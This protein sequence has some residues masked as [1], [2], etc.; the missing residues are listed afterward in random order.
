MEQ[1]LLTRADA[2]GL[3]MELIEDEVSRDDFDKGFEQIQAFLRTLS[4]EGEDAELD[5]LLIDLLDSLEDKRSEL[6]FAE[7]EKVWQASL[8]EKEAVIEELRSLIQEE[9]NIGK[10]FQSF[11]ELRDKWEAIGEVS[12]EQYSRVHTEYSRLRE[13]FFYNISIYKEL[14]DHDKKVNL[15]LKKEL[16]EKAKELANEKNIQAADSGIKEVIKKWDDIGGTFQ[17]EWELV[18]EEF[19]AASRT[20]LDRVNAYYSDQRERMAENLQKKNQLITQ[21]TDIADKDRS[22]TKEWNNATE[23]VLKIQEEWKRIGFSAENEKVWRSFREACD[24]FFKAKQGFYDQIKEVFEERKKRKLILIQK[25]A[26]MKD[27]SDWRDASAEIIAI[28]NEW[29]EVGS[30]S[31]KDENKLWNTFRG[32]CDAFFNNRN[33]HF[34][35]RDSEEK[36]NLKL[37]EEVIVELKTFKPTGNRNKDIESVRALSDRWNAVGHVPFKVK[38]KVYKEYQ[39][40]L[41][42]FYGSVKMDAQEKSKMQ[43]LSRVETLKGNPKA[44]NR[45]KD[46]LRNEIK[47]L[48]DDIRQYENNL[49]FFNTRDGEN[50]LMKDVQRK[51]ERNREKVDELM[52]LLRLS[53]KD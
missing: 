9:E 15:R 40:L 30:A 16:V 12:Q 14:A 20:V 48:M 42:D 33:Q 44:L 3:M 13:T 28:Q 52:A 34:K 8:K 4:S 36:E 7:K 50:P 2:L 53:N 41:D 37:K 26:G 22:K 32:H 47:K 31:Q 24:S 19:W 5:G 38:D 18:R 29:K 49:G 35:Q 11:N 17:K 1:E 6:D 21:V 10:A 25:V 43:Y 39:R 23:K 51:I 27:R 46:N 45:E